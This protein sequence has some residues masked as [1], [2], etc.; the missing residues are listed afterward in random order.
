M[1]LLTSIPIT[2]EAT[3]VKNMGTRSI[4]ETETKANVTG[5]YPSFT[6]RLDL[7]DI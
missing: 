3:N 1:S 4:S 2:K 5:Y 7:G 6:G